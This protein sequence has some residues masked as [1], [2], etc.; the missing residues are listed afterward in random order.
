[1]KYLMVVETLTVNLCVYY[2]CPIVPNHN[3]L[4]WWR[5]S[6]SGGKAQSGRKEGEGEAN[7]SSGNII[8][9]LL[10]ISSASVPHPHP[11][12]WIP[13]HRTP[14]LFPTPVLHLLL[15]PFLE[16]GEGRKRRYHYTFYIACVPA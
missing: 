9:T 10:T 12:L 5:G 13:P 8:L 6:G 4:E 1:M 16:A 7:E 3:R 14:L 11:T 15:V 2:Y